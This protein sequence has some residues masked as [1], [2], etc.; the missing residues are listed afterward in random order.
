MWA[1]A[2]PDL[3]GWSMELP[4]KA[5]K[6]KLHPQGALCGFRCARVV[7]T[8]TANGAED[9]GLECLDCQGQPRD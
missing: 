5:N 6:A 1:R 8:R 9:H 3:A 2:R 7:T 4:R